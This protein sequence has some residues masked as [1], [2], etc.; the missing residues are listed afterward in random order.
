MH[1]GDAGGVAG[2]A[3]GLGAAGGLLRPRRRLQ[4]LAERDRPARG[5]RRSGAKGTGHVRV[6]RHAADAHRHRSPGVAGGCALPPAR[7]PRRGVLLQVRCPLLL[8]DC[9]AKTGRHKG[10]EEVLVPQVRDA[11]AKETS[12]SDP[13]C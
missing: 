6:P 11:H 13:S 3:A 1:W 9:R 2:G 8:Q 10:G 12:R 4:R 5:Q 7:S